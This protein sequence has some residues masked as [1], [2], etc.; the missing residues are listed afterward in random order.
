MFNEIFLA[1][2]NGRLPSV[3]LLPLQAGG[4][5][6]CATQAQ[7]ATHAHA[8]PSATQPPVTQASPILVGCRMHAGQVLSGEDHLYCG[9]RAGRV[10]SERPYCLSLAK[11][12]LVEYLFTQKQKQYAPNRANSIHS[13]AWD[14]VS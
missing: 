1:V 4:L 2:R 3:D 8:M 13:L 5:P 9:L 14:A 12:S 11:A 7:I 10:A 6:V